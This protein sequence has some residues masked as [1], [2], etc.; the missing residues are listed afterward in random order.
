MEEAERTVCRTLEEKIAGADVFR[1]V[2]I[3]GLGVIGGSLAMALTQG[4]LVDEVIGVDRDE[5]TRKLALAT[6]A[7]HR[8]EADAAE[9]VA[10]ADL[11]VLATPV[12]TYPAIIASIRHRLKPGTIVTDVGS[13]KQWVLEQMGRLLPPGVRFVGGH[14]MAGSEKQGIRGADRYLLENAVYVLTPDVDTDAAALQA[15]EDL[16]KAAGARVLRI[17][18]E[19]HDSMVALVSHLPHMMAVALVETLSEVAKEYP[20]APM[21]AAGGFRDT[22]RVAA[23][24]PQMWVDIACTNREPL[25]HMI[26]CFRSA[27]DRLE[28]QIDACG[29]CGSKMEALRETL[30]H[31]REVRLSIPGKAKGILPGIHEIVLTV[32][33]EP[34]VIGTIARLLGD[35]GINIADIEILRVR[36]GHGGTIRIGFYEAPDADGAVEVLAGAG[37]IVKRW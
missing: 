7:A 33:D 3:I 26:G 29:A 14:P 24:D 16:I 15:L 37:I 25:L 19:E 8:V 13:T 20:K 30:A 28:E 35:N 11:I 36:E 12:C 6:Y 1:R 32:P 34:G 17:S 18:A 31:A 5:E 21:L 23:G 9:A 4:Q 2:V 27:L 22:T 10:E